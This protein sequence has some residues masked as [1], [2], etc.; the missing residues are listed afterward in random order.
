[1]YRI[2]QG[3]DV[4][5]FVADRPLILCGVEIPHHVGLLGHSDADVAVHAVMDAMLGA[6]D[7]VAQSDWLT[8]VPGVMMA[9]E[10]AG[11]RWTVGPVAD[12]GLSVDLMLI[13]PSK[14]PLDAPTAAFLGVLEQETLRVNA[15]W[16]EIA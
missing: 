9:S 2:G 16:G 11:G 1:M 12:P 4:H 10:P 14:Q 3:V 7:L 5:R 13:E 8:V 6:L 15:V